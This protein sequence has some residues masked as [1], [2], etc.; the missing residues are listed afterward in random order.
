[1]RAAAT[2]AEAAAR[3]AELDREELDWK[4][5]VATYL[6]EKKRLEASLVGRSEEERRAALQHS[7]DGRFS[8][9]QQKRLGAYE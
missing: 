5:R 6:A 8:K 3:L 2:T 7:R 9:D 1:M 4:N